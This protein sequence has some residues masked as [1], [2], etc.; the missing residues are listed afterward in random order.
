M[1]NGLVSQ[2]VT[3]RRFLV[4]QR[5]AWRKFTT[6]TSTSLIINTYSRRYLQYR[7]PFR[8]HVGTLLNTSLSDIHAANLSGFSRLTPLDVEVVSYS[9][10]SVFQIRTSSWVRDFEVADLLKLLA[11][12]WEDITVE[13]WDLSSTN[14]LLATMLALTFLRFS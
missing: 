5:S 3:L 9:Y 2:L 8:R 13:V 1:W 12:F 14:L 7:R 6:I 11:V 4:C 10:A